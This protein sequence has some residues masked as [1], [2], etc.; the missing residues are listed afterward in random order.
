MWKP[1]E[2]RDEA[3]LTEVV[4]RNENVDEY[5]SYHGKRLGDVE[6]GEVFEWH[7]YNANYGGIY[8]RKGDT[9]HLLSGRKSENNIL[10]PAGQQPIMRQPTCSGNAMG[11]DNEVI[12]YGSLGDDL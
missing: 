12:V 4:R 2:K 5:D 8:Y 9:A 6:D 11:Y 10:S 1:E 7:A 3:D